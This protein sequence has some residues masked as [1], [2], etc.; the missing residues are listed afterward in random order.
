MSS[1]L[2][3]IIT[4]SRS[5]IMNV[6]P[7]ATGRTSATARAAIAPRSQRRRGPGAAGVGAG[8]QQQ[9]RD[10]A[11]HPPR[12]AERSGD[13][14]LVLLVGRCRL[15]PLLEQ[16]EVGE[17]AGQR[18]AQLVRG[19]GDELALGCIICSVS[20]RAASSSRSISSSVRASSATSSSVSG[21]GM[22]REGSRVVAISRAAAVS[23][24]IGLIARRAIAIRRARRA[25]FRRAPRGRGRARSGS[26]VDV[27][28]PRA[29]GRT[30]RTPRGRRRGRDL[31]AGDGQSPTCAAPR[32]G[33]PRSRRWPCRDRV[34]AD[35]DDLDGASR[36]GRIV[37]PEV[38]FVESRR[39]PSPGRRRAR[40]G[41]R[42]WPPSS[43]P[44]RRSLSSSLSTASRPTTSAKTTRMTNVSPAE[45][46]AIASAPASG[47]EEGG[48]SL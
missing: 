1:G 19:V 37:E 44:P 28:R 30:G 12:R 47:R 15:E 29:H 21:I 2:Q 3:S 23:D 34:S 42:C 33:G 32:V 25:W 39:R 31:L 4:G 6:W 35:V 9:V 7:P 38:S 48:P 40:S 5:S 26:I 41:W 27:E 45:T 11:P 24:E 18:G 36:G 13:D 8:E 43:A 20:E 17:D 16:L 10:E 14:L 46:A 22:R